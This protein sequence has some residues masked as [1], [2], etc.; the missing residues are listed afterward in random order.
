[1]GKKRTGSA[2]K[3]QAK[4]QV[5]A[6]ILVAAMAV[7]LVAYFG[8]VGSG[9]AVPRQVGVSGPAGQAYV[10]EG[11]RAYDAGDYAGAI[12]AYEK[13]LPQRG[14]DPALLTDLGTAYFYK[15]PSDPVR[16]TVYYDQALAVDPQFPNA[17]F[18]KGIVLMQGL[19]KPAEAI[20][21]LEKLLSFL[22]PNDPQTARVKESIARAKA[23]TASPATV[24]SGQPTSP[25]APGQV[26]QV[27]PPPA[28]GG[29]RLATGFGR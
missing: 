3:R 24:P 26:P 9:P 29:S 6:L 15:T 7:S 13:A 18:N 10:D 11:N 1:M 27:A 21:V 20:P 28:V 16:A 2:K 25:S 8:S 19:G 23:A 4:G 5:V 14:Q 12:R 17:L 22:S